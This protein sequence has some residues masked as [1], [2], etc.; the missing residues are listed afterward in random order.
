MGCFWRGVELTEL[1]PNGWIHDGQV[2][3]IRL[4]NRVHEPLPDDLSVTLLRHGGLLRSALKLQIV[5]KKG[6]VI[7][8]RARTL[9]PLGPFTVFIEIIPELGMG[10]L[11]ERFGPLAD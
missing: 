5:F 8:S 9:Q 4:H 10:N 7:R 1:R 6:S 2:G 11:D 3:L